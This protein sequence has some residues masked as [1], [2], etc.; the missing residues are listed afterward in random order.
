MRQVDDSRI[1]M[2]VVSTNTGLFNVTADWGFGAI[3]S[4]VDIE[5]FRTSAT[6]DF[7]RLGNVQLPTSGLLKYDLPSNT[8]TTF[9][10]T[11][12]AVDAAATDDDAP[13]DATP[14]V[15]NDEL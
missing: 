11:F 14:I 5:V 6:E 1:E 9:H 10:M 2:A 3:A 7:A 13:T 15:D 12:N 4:P 8:I